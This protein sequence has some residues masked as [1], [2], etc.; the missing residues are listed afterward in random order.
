MPL[1][2]HSATTGCCHTCSCSCSAAVPC[3]RIHRE[4]G[5]SCNLL[6]RL[7]DS[8]VV[9][10]SADLNTAHSFNN[11]NV[12]NEVPNWRLHPQAGYNV[13]EH[14][15]LA[16]GRFYAPVTGYYFCALNSRLDSMVT[17]WNRMTLGVNGDVDYQRGFMSIFQYNAHYMPH[18]FAGTLRL[19]K[20]SYVSVFAVANGDHSWYPHMLCLPPPCL[21]SPWPRLPAVSFAASAAT[22][23]SNR[24]L[25]WRRPTPDIVKQRCHCVA[26]ASLSAAFW[27]C[28]AALL[29]LFAQDGS[30]RDWFLLPP[31]ERGGGRRGRLLC[32]HGRQVRYRLD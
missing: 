3:R 31:A 23:H 29:N 20:D 28:A 10:F 17:H 2:Q 21:L 25:A 16:N 12:Q 26:L 1:A 14:F 8:G 6:N 27:L 32:E 22:T 5:F 4:S 30:E 19:E 15:N 11:V 24:Q 18:N 7:S 13:G 9:G